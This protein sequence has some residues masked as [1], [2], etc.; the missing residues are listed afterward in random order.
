M[1][2][3]LELLFELLLQIA[4]Q[5]L[6]SVGMHAISKQFRK[7]PSPWPD[8]IVWVLVGLALGAISL[9]A[10]PSHLVKVFA[11]QLVNLAVTPILAGACVAAFARW[12]AG[13]GERVLRVDRFGYGYL[14]ALSFALVRFT[15]AS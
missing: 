12:K 4:A 3:I 8:A 10:L 7:R 15:W 1:E 9:G 11:W 6:A 13:R 14:F 2:I 5:V